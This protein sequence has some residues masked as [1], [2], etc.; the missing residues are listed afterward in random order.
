MAF[1]VSPSPDCG[2]CPRL[3]EFRRNNRAEHP[4]WSNAPVESFGDPLARLLIVGLA[5]GA[6]RRKSHWPAVHRRLRR[7]SPLRDS[8]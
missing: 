7:R 8:A 3:A 2:F 6:S 1:D 4:D 5:P